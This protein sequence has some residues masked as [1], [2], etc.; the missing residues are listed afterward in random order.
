NIRGWLKTINNG[1]TEGNDL[2]GFVLK[3]NDPTNG[4]ALYNGNISE[5]HWQ[6]ASDHNPRSY[7]YGYDALNR[8]KTATYHGNY[9]LLE[10]PLETENYSLGLVNYDKNGNIAYLNRLGLNK[11]NNEI[12][13]IDDLT[14]NYVP[15]SNTLIS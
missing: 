2:F 5:T 14:Y 6:T 1:N 8:L 15:V 12:D 11:V 10:N 13:Y 4:I 3:Y 9:T 7:D